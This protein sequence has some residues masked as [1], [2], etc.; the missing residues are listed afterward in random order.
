MVPQFVNAKLTHI[1]W[2]TMVYGRYNDELVNGVYKPTYDW[3]AP[4]CMCMFKKGITLLHSHEILTLIFT[5]MSL[6][7]NSESINP[8]NSTVSGWWY[9]YPSEK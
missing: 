4:H 8:S 6:S 9:T 2:L 5:I 7:T 3:G 1:T